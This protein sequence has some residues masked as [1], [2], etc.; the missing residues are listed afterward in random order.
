LP[1]ETKNYIRKLII[2]SLIAKSDTLLT[3]IKSNK[4]PPSKPYKSK[5]ELLSKR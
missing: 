5:K 2:A 1:K 3:A 4:K